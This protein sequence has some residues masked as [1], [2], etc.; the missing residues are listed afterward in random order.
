MEGLHQGHMVLHPS[1]RRVFGTGL[2]L[3]WPAVRGESPV[4]MQSLRQIQ[5]ACGL[6]ISWFCVR[7][8][9]PTFCLRAGHY[10]IL[11]A[12]MLILFS[13]LSQA[14]ITT[15]NSPER[16]RLQAN[17]HEGHER[18]GGSDPDR[19][20]D[21]LYRRAQAAYQEAAPRRDKQTRANLAAAI[22]LFRESARLFEAGHLYDNAADAYLQAA[23]I[24]FSVSKYDEAR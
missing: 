9:S 12:G 21:V 7:P 24:Y 3:L 5:R 10:L 20:Q 15:P 6:T 16:G 1:E 13:M 4:D 22:R 17:S 18:P 2:A 14:Q 8:G 11:Q 19:N 23:E